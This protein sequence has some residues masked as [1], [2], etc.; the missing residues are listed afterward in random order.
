MSERRV[1]SSGLV[2]G[3]A[4]HIDHGKTS[5]VGALT[6]TD[7]DR[8]A[9]EK[10]RGI[11]IDLGFA[12]LTL[13]NGKTAGFV[14]VPG[15]ER[16][17]KNM[18]AGA[19]G[20]QAV[21]LIVAADESVMPQTREH[22]QICR[23]LGIGHGFVV[24][25]K[26]DLA[27]PEQMAQ[28]R[29]DVQQLCA[30]SFLDGAAMVAVSSVTGQGLDEV[31]RELTLLSDN[32]VS[33]ETAAL[34]RLPVDRS[35]SLTGFGTVVTG[36][37]SAGQFR[38]GESV[39]LH[40]GGR[41]LRIRGIQ[42]HGSAVETANA[43][44]RTAI[45]LNGIESS[46]IRRGS[47]L[48]HVDELEASSLLDVC[49]DWLPGEKSPARKQQVLLHL[50]TAEIVAELKMFD[51]K[52]ARLSL[53]EPALALPGDRFILRKPTPART[54][55]GG[56]VVDSFP[57]LGRNRARTVARLR[58][59]A[60]GDSARCIQLLVEEGVNGRLVGELVRAT[61]LDSVRIL[62]L[63]KSNADLFFHSSTNR[64]LSKRWLGAK[65]TELLD[66]L[67]KF[68]AA[69]PS[70]AGAPISSARLNLPPEIAAILMD[71]FPA[72]RV[73]GDFIALAG[74]RAVFNDQESRAL[75]DIEN[76]FRQAGYQPPQIDEVLRSAVPDPKK[77]RALLELLVKNKKLVRITDGL[78]FHADVMTHVRSSL[79][80][81]KGRRFSVPEFKEWTQMSRKYAIPV[82]EYLDREKV[83]RRDG[84]GRVIV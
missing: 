8:L 26:A 12:Y 51:D 32:V 47:T 1:R 2:I 6:G 10:R 40:P 58:T 74:H 43:G 52:L 14:D 5:L 36:T 38:T 24:L 15:H 44:Q 28:A 59:L 20:I 54:I 77:A 34:A 13:P 82:L 7:T 83:T 22:F 35:F 63:V 76:A 73:Q 66:W 69:N 49:I 62:S 45:N 70:A 80:A 11:S 29:S 3:T 19:V 72:V 30:G 48:T 9:E 31:I 57:P 75:D 84:D 81:H 41:Q 21:M 18:L 55:A 37:L 46:E 65:R 4:G 53:A 78:I 60:A 39:R 27:S 50:G 33:R 42:V 64:A 71:G 25:T 23:L 68:H 17:I 16:F 56:S 79:S 67:R 61:G